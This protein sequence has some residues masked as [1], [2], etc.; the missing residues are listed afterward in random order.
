MKKNIP[1]EDEYKPSR[2]NSEVVETKTVSH[3]EHKGWK[4]SNSNLDS[5]WTSKWHCSSS[6]WPVYLLKQSSLR[7]TISKNEG[8][9][10]RSWR[11][12]ADKRL[13]WVLVPNCYSPL[14][15]CRCVTD[16]CLRAAFPLDSTH[17]FHPS[18][19]IQ[20]KQTACNRLLQVSSIYKDCR[21]R[22]PNSLG[23]VGRSKRNP[24]AY[25]MS[26]PS[27]SECR[28]CGRTLDNTTTIRLLPFTIYFDGLLVVVDGQ[29][30]VS[31]HVLDIPIAV[32]V[33]VMVGLIPCT[34]IHIRVQGLQCFGHIPAVIFHSTSEE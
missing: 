15:G 32:V 9:G 16:R 34:L 6:E 26:E 21:E 24:H 30:E 14:A 22:E 10:E 7:H 12:P 13:E 31:K 4:P 25:S 8:L 20:K 1:Y 23:T 29:R 11:T 17:S 5:T 33:H 19:S 28:A 3:P 2:S 18:Y 27:S